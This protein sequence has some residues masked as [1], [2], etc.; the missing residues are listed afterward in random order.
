MTP[1]NSST[2]L[3]GK[4]VMST[5]NWEGLYFSAKIIQKFEF[6]FPVFVFAFQAMKVGAFFPFLMV[7]AEYNEK[8]HDLL[9]HYSLIEWYNVNSVTDEGIDLYCDGLR[10]CVRLFMPFMRRI[11]VSTGIKEKELQEYC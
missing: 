5:N 1:Q 9:K 3:H 7:F 2:F 4:P 11:D 10:N 6:N 8:E